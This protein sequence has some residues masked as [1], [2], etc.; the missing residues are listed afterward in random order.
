M[1]LAELPKNKK[2]ILFDGVCDFC[3]SAINKII[4]KDRK[5]IFV[6]ASLQSETGQQILKHVGLTTNPETIVLYEPEIGYSTK[7]DAALKIA[8]NLGGIYS[9]ALIGYV[10][11]TAIRNKIYD[12]VARN[13]YK[14]YGK[15]DVCM[16]PT[17][18]VRSKFL[19]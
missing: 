16:V 19:G 8:K 17:P 18:E 15:R 10:L 7:S 3:N 1:E 13:R 14:W 5:N 9:L 6:F 11:P 2:I 4:A 12:Y